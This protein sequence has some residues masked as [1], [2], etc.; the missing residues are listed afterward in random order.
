M[1]NNY[2]Q[3]FSKDIPH[4]ESLKFEPLLPRYK[5]LKFLEWGVF[6]FI[7]IGIGFTA[8]IFMPEMQTW[9]LYTFFG[10]CSLWI[11]WAFLSVHFG[12]PHKGFAIREQ[13]VHYQTGWLK[14]S[15]I[16]VPICRIQH[17]QVH[18]SLL[19]KAFK[20]AKLNIYTAGDSANDMTIKG[21][22]L[23]KAQTIKDLISDKINE[24]G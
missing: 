12:F 20:L 14:H 15:I 7:F 2:E 18:Q 10:F 16:S 17:M 21:I 9:M 5:K 3:I 4:S 8:Y 24:N 23:E 1:Q 22:S 11:I 19:S 13:D 6:F